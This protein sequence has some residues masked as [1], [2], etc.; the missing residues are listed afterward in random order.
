MPR[1]VRFRRAASTSKVSSR[2]AAEKSSSPRSSTIDPIDEQGGKGD[3][4]MHGARRGVTRWPL[5]SACSNV[6]RKIPKRNRRENC[7]GVALLGWHI[8]RPATSS[9][10]AVLPR[11][12][13]VPRGIAPLGM[14]VAYTEDGFNPARMRFRVLR[15]SI[16]QLATELIEICVADF[17][18]ANS[19][20]LGAI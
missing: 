12:S 15:I 11:S 16:F 14:P 20:E 7:G 18:N 13:P 6:T 2:R 8:K 3:T 1:H 17:A 4:G 9:V 10:L 5:V 19:E